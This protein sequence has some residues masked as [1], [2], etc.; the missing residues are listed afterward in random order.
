M[1]DGVPRTRTVVIVLAIVALLVMWQSVTAVWGGAEVRQGA[2]QAR[3]TFLDANIRAY[4]VE[5]ATSCFCFNT[6]VRVTVVDGDIVR[7]E[8]M[9]LGDWD[10][11]FPDQVLA[12]THTLPKEDRWLE[13]YLVFPRVF[14]TIAAQ[15]DAD[16]ID[17]D[18]D[19]PFGTPTEFFV[20]PKRST[21]DDEF[22]ASWLDFE[23][24]NR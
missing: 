3:H 13:R 14:G 10:D 12:T 18:F 2:R 17:A 8:R 24:L 15:S 11:P 16:V 9:K 4:R 22:S 6:H 1:H 20:N 7:V 21:F 23:V 19:G 5:F